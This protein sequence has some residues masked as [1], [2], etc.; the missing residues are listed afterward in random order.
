MD[1]V[2]RQA[3]KSVDQLRHVA[4]V[5]RE[6]G[7]SGDDQRHSGITY[8]VDESGPIQ[9]LHLGWHRQLA[10]QGHLSS[11]YFWVDPQVPTA[12]LRQ[13][14]AICEDIAH[15]NLVEQ[16][17]YSF[18]SPVNA[19]DDRTKKFLLGPTT[20][21]L[22]CASFVLAVF[23]RAQLRLARYMGW[24]APDLDDIRW[25]QSVLEA[26]RNDPRVSPEHINAVEREVGNSVRYRPEQVAGAAAIRK[27][28]P[29]KYQYAKSL[30]SEIVRFLRGEQ[31]IGE[32]RLS[33]WDRLLDRL[34]LA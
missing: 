12:R 6:V 24:A 5:I 3:D 4:V 10:Q 18:G 13:V 11:K 8:R 17:P 21:G 14:A 32:Y 28:R 1:R 30:G 15:A 25:Q 31:P 16:I 19:F 26:L 2:H 7:D 20:T 22:T 27:R 33:R 23:E 34:G 9:F 29:V